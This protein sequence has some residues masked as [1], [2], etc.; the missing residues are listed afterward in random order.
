MDNIV[1]AKFG[2]SSLSDSTQFK[3]VKEIVLEDKNRRY[4][5]PSAPGKRYGGDYKITDLLY[6]SYDHAKNGIP[7]EEVYKFIEERYIQIC[8]ELSLSIDIRTRLKDF[9]DKI[10][11]GASKDYTAS[12]GEYFNGLI[13]AEYLGFDFIDSS[14]III[15]KKNGSLNEAATYEAVQNRLKDVE[16][17]VIPGFYG[18][19]SD[20]KI[21]TFS[22]GGSDITGAI[23]AKSVGSVMYENWTDVSGFLMTDP[24]IVDSPKPIK[25]ITYKELRELSYMGANVF[26]EEAV[27]PVKNDG[28]PINIKNTN[29]PEDEGTFIVDDKAAARIGEITGISGKKDFTVIALEKA[30]MNN[31]KGYMKKVLQVLEQNDISF[32]HVPS[33]IDSI[34]LVIDNNQLENTLDNTI[35]EIQLMCNPDSLTVYPNMALI[36]VVGKGMAFT[37]G[38]SAKI[39]TAMAKNNINVRLI[40]QGSNELSIIIGVE[41]EDF[42]KSIQ[43]IYAEF[44]K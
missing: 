8:D 7:F 13:L 34:S 23:I 44:N 22:R 24:R 6:L 40:I 20:G 41:N 1:V 15:F 2:G 19:T 42:E 16:Y 33:G 35:E 39:F 4:I 12:R 32:E 10:V 3:K 30:L 25:E 27:F 21:K 11:S 18:S 17:A 14:E 31:E 28:I 26:H 9:R 36:A 37:K 38:I 5:I 43:A 29:K